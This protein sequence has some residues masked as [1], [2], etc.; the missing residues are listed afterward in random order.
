MFDKYKKIKKIKKYQSIRDVSNVPICLAPFNSLFFAPYGRIMSCWY[1]KREPLGN[2]SEDSIDEVWFGEKLKKLRSHLLKFDF[3]QGCEVCYSNLIKKNYYSV[4]AFRYDYL[5][6]DKSNYPTS[7]EFQISHQCNLECIMCNGEL[8]SSVRQNREKENLYKN[9]YDDKFVE[10]LMPYLPYLKDVAFSGGEPFLNKI[11]FDIWEHLSLINPKVKVSLTTNGSVLNEKV[12]EYLNKLN[13]SISVSIDSLDEDNYAYIRKN[14]K[15]RNLLDNFQYFLNYTHKAGTSISVKTCP[16]KQNIREMPSIIEFANTQDVP[17]FFNTVV[18]PPNCTLI[19]EKADTLKEHI[20]YLKFYSFENMENVRGNFNRYYSLI[21]QLEGW[22]KNAIERESKYRKVKTDYNYFFKEVQKNISWF[23]TQET[24]SNE[25][26]KK[27]KVKFYNQFLSEVLSKVSD[28]KIKFE[29]IKYFSE[30]PIFRVLSE[31]EFRDP[32]RLAER[33]MFW[34]F[35]NL[36]E[37]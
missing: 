5:V 24:D 19:N 11:Y 25:I 14:G 4:D 2:Y 31:I 1:N 32:Q 37:K 9:P 29:A 23:I 16:M 6:N 8:S 22:W 36:N 17:V 15:L 33:L 34:D 13:F 28:E 10:K 30:I 27:E 35:N 3:S 7:F 26:E 21:S 20:S 12:K 18:Y